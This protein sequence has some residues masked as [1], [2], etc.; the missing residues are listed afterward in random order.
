MREIANSANERE[1]LR[2]KS[3]NKKKEFKITLEI[4]SS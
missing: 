4:V 3:E 1:I 2:V